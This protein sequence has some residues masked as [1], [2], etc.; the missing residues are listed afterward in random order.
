MRQYWDSQEQVG[1]GV[2]APVV[3]H[4]CQWFKPYI[5]AI[6]DGAQHNILQWLRWLPRCLASR[7]L[8]DLVPVSCIQPLD[9]VK[10]KWVADTK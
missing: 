8:V 7:L 6:R 10:H 5:S 1:Q 9:T 3:D 4:W 2:L